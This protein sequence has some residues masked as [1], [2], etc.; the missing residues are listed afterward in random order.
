[1]NAPR[2]S[3]KTVKTEPCRLGNVP[4]RPM[5]FFIGAIG[6]KALIRWPMTGKEEIVS[7]SAII[8]F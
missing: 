4:G 6:G 3:S 8:K 2:K 7:T 5:V 1:M